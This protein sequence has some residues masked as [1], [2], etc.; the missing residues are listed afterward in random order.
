MRAPATDAPK[1]PR[2]G[3]A[4]AAFQPV[5]QLFTNSAAQ[6]RIMH[7]DT[8]AHIT[9]S[10]LIRTNQET[11]MG[12]FTDKTKGMIKE[13]IGDVTD[14]KGLKREGERDQFKGQAERTVKDVKNAV[15]DATESAKNA[16]KDTTEAIKDATKT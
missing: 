12:E 5:S 2:F 3:P 4:E 7:P 10:F 1:G 16:V 15:K 9:V 6:A 8:S 13:V 14:N 11:N